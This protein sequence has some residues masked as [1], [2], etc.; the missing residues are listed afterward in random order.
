MNIEELDELKKKTVVD[1][2]NQE[3]KINEFINR[4][5]T[6]E[7]LSR[8]SYFS[9]ITI[10]SEK[11]YKYIQ[12]ANLEHLAGIILNR[13]FV[14]KEEIPN[15]LEIDD[16]IKTIDHFMSYWKIS[17]YLRKIDFDLSEKELSKAIVAANMTS[18]YGIVRGYSW[19][20]PM[21][22]QIIDLLNNYD[23]YLEN[24][25]GFT[26][27]DCFE[28]FEHLT[29]LYSEK[30]EKLAEKSIT[31]ANEMIPFILEDYKKGEIRDKNIKKIVKN[32]SKNHKK[33]IHE[34]VP[35]ILFSESLKDE[36]LFSSFDIKVD[37]EK[38]K[39][40]NKFLEFFSTNIAEEVQEY[41]FPSDDNIFRA[42]PILK[43]EDSYLLMFPNSLRWT[44]QEQMEKV[45]QE[46]EE[47]WNEYGQIKGDYLEKETIN[48][49][50]KILPEAD[51]HSELYYK[52]NGERYELD[53]LVLYDSNLFIIESKSRGF[54][55]PAKKGGLG[56]LKK[57]I[58]ENIEYALIQAKRAKDFIESKEEVC[59][60]NRSGK[61]VLKLQSETYKNKFI[62]NTTLD[63]FAD[64]TTSLTSLKEVGLYKAEEYPWSISLADF[65]VI[66]DFIEFPTQFIHYAFLRT[67][68]NDNIA[69]KS[70]YELDIFGLYLFQDQEERQDYHV[71]EIDIGKVMKNIILGTQENV[72]SEVLD[73]SP[74]Y[75]RHYY[76]KNVGL[77]SEPY[78]R[79][80]NNK[81]KIILMEL[82]QLNQYGHTTI[83][84]KLIDLYMNEQDTIIEMYDRVVK[85][86]QNDGNLHD[87]SKPVNYDKLT[88]SI[89]GVTIM[90][91]YTRDR[92]IILEKLKAHCVFKMHQSQAKEWIGLCT[93]L[94][95]RRKIVN[96]FVYVDE[97]MLSSSKKNPD[98]ISLLNMIDQET[99]KVGRTLYK[100]GRNDPC[101]C[102]S[103][104]KYKK[105]HGSGI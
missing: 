69:L 102:G 58:Q 99:K 29:Q 79:K 105:C 38:L 5:D 10:D 35:Y 81:F 36:L 67:R 59:F 40:L 85:M 34:L 78:R 32:Y 56:R 97:D 44:L 87:I 93:F 57:N 49:M 45:I 43:Y 80:F 95:D 90:S 68:M 94:D 84:L 6:I 31:R 104:V 22:Q 63:Y 48:V 8:L 70:T 86:T 13:T 72:Y 73:Y 62:M 42:K 53:G 18:N 14:V 47:M 20:T 96:N 1:L 25:I 39:K 37:D 11:G 23:E 88:G 64:I 33:A 16:L 89:Y 71:E 26:I 30:L 65:K 2:Q 27:G 17:N 82:N 19:F 52:H 9:Y 66:S 28:F 61:K 21:Q 103:G 100:A 4:F 76:D 74:I 83:G 101:P 12:P 46:N 55:S 50:R 54:H 92:V 15:P 41:R 51:I 75:N 98:F 24:T 77:S 60:Y 7:M 91:G 3:M